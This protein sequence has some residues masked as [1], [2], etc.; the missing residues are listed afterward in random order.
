MLA[1]IVYLTAIT[2]ACAVSVF[3]GRV[4]IAHAERPASI[5]RRLTAIA[6]W[7]AP[8][9]IFFT[10]RGSARAVSAPALVTAAALLVA[11]SVW[12]LDR[13]T[14]P[15]DLAFATGMFSLPHSVR[16]TRQLPLSIGLAL[17]AELIVTL[18]MAGAIFSAVLLAFPTSVLCWRAQSW[19]PQEGKLTGLT[20]A[21]AVMLTV[22]GLSQFL[23][24]GGG[25]APAG[26][27]KSSGDSEP[28][29]ESDTGSGVG[30]FVGVI[31]IPNVEKHVTLVPPLPSMSRKVFRKDDDNPLTIPFY[32]VY[33]F[34][35]FPAVRPPATSVTLHGKPEDIRFR[36]S[37][38]VPL[39][40][41]A[42]QNLGKLIDVS[43]CSRIQVAIHNLD[44]VDNSQ[45]AAGPNR[46]QLS[47]GNT[48][49]RQP[50]ESLGMDPIDGAE[51]QVLDF[52]LRPDLHL[53]QFDE[54]TVR[55][56]RGWTMSQS[57]R[58]SVE[59]FVLVPRGR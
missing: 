37:G 2:T 32:G 9:A 42:H 46:V 5:I 30:E 7:F 47:L 16:L 24:L 54:L 43:C 28:A 58:I 48:T 4:G 29:S 56:L 35:R 39:T 33:W 6:I 27:G 3:I 22:A 41:E 53:R 12:W 20:A 1:T 34:Y 45:H 49:A 57:A 14:S 59:R 25:S 10:S 23:A 26:A 21:A 38:Y 17:L 40:M 50:A 8:A 11:A 44:R 31:L 13:P 19:I 51:H 18:V 36:S 15:P 52:P 55:I